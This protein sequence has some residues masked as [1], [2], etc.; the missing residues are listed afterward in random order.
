MHAGVRE[1]VFP[2]GGVDLNDYRKATELR[3]PAHAQASP[4]QCV[5]ALQQLVFLPDRRRTMADAFFL[6]CLLLSGVVG[7]RIVHVD[8]NKDCMSTVQQCRCERFHYLPAV[9][10]DGLGNI[11]EVPRGI[12]S[13]SGATLQYI[14]F[15]N[16][17]F[18]HT[19]H[20]NSFK[21]FKFRD[22]YMMWAQLETIE[23][24]AFAGLEDTIEDL[25]LAFNKLKSFD[26]FRNLR[27]LQELDLRANRFTQIT[28]SDLAPFAKTLTI[29]Q[30]SYNSLSHLEADVF[31]PLV[32]L[33]GLYLSGCHLLTLEATVNL[34]I[35]PSMDC[36]APT[37]IDSKGNSTLKD[38]ALKF[39]PAALGP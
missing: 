20:N 22:L 9:S 5:R 27:N 12:H 23:P 1:F 38:T 25:N 18:L 10:C 24:L 35:I 13:A 7:A 11:T 19:L 39:V 37:R 6:L 16:G 2:Y 15:N 8:A 36:K 29:L 33:R 28:K 31:V 4:L 30:M 17:T 14:Q 34:A 26:G 21:E 32:R 3:V